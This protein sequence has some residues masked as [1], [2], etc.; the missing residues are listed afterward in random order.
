MEL[1]HD[2][3]EAPQVLVAGA[4]KDIVLA[5][6]TIHLEQINFGQFFTRQEFCQRL[7]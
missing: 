4:F 1:L 3:F 2:P 6:I 7:A 5:P